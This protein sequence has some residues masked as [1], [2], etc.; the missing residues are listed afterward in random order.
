VFSEGSYLLR[1]GGSH[2]GG[3]QVLALGAAQGGFVELEFTEPG[4]YPFLNHAMVDAERGA[5]GTFAV[6]R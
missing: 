6:R 2:G 4:H 5:A 1:R 3:S